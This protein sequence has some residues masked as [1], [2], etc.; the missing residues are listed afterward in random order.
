[1][2]R[3]TRHLDPSPALDPASSRL[4]LRCGTPMFDALIRAQNTNRFPLQLY[5]LQLQRLRRTSLLWGNEFAETTCS[6]LVCPACGYTELVA[7][8]PSALLKP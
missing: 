8:N 2:D 5:P 3:P 1:M 7:A 4:C 6:V